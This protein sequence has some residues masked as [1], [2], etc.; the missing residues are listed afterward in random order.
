MNPSNQH[1]SSKSTIATFPSFPIRALHLVTLSIFAAAQPLFD[2]LIQ[3]T[4][5][6]SIRRSEPGDLFGLVFILVFVVPLPLIALTGIGGWLCEFG[7]KGVQASP[8]GLLTMLS[9]GP[10]KIAL[11]AGVMHTR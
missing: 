6:F 7:K 2:I 11:P 5:F 8:L 10:H 3:K 4:E 9:H 1:Q